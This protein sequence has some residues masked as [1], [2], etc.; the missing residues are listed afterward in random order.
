MACHWGLQEI[1]NVYSTGEHM[2]FR[3]RRMPVGYPQQTRQSPAA[4]AME[5]DG[6]AAAATGV[7]DGTVGGVCMCK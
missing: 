1:I 4:V 3:N 6:A 7:Q 5:G 2:V